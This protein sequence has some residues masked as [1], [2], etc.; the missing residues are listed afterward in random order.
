[1]FFTNGQKSVLFGLMNFRREL[2]SH[3]LVRQ[4]FSI[5]IW[6]GVTRA[7]TFVGS[8][9]AMRCLGPQKL[10]VSSMIFAAVTPLS[11]LARSIWTF[12]S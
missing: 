8:I 2:I 4:A 5:A 9:W 6:Q 12:C 10:G 11:L 3:R 7:C 1:M